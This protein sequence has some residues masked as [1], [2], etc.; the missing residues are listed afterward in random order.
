MAPAHHQTG[1]SWAPAR[2]ALY[3]S[4]NV[5]AGPPPPTRRTQRRSPLDCHPHHPTP[6]THLE[7]AV[8]EQLVGALAGAARAH[9]A[10]HLQGSPQHGLQGGGLGHGRGGL[11][12]RRPVLQARRTGKPSVEARLKGM[13]APEVI[14]TPLHQLSTPICTGPAGGRLTLRNLSPSSAA[15]WRRRLGALPAHTL[16]PKG[17]VPAPI[18]AAPM[19]PLPMDSPSALPAAAAAAAAAPPPPLAAAPAVPAAP[20]GAASPSVPSGARRLRCAPLPPPPRLPAPMPP[21]LPLMVPARCGLMPN[22]CRHLQGQGPPPSNYA[23][24]GVLVCSAVW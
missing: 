13:N 24:E 17:V 20:A 12:G 8:P 7:E 3:N 21:L 9:G 11:R 1:S 14:A 19:A 6:P 22:K 2:V 10:P 18:G 15:D 16:A 4:K 23:R 5:A